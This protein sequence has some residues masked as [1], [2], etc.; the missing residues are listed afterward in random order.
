[1]K[2]FNSATYGILAATA[3][4]WFPSGT[5]AEIDLET[6][7]KKH[8]NDPIACGCRDHEKIDLE[9]RIKQVEAAIKEYESLIKEWEAKERSGKEQL[10][11]TNDNR[12]SVQGSVGFRMST[13]RTPNARSF[14]AET[15]PTCKTWVDPNATPC[16][17][18]A[19]QDHESVHK[20]ACDANK[21][22][23]PFV[24]WRSKQRLVDY[25]REE[26]AGYQ[27]ELDRLKSELETMK[28][29]CSLDKSVRWALENRVAEQ[30]RQRAAYDRVD[31]LRKVL[32]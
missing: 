27:K 18:G 10:L 31:G 2:I 6:E 32:R 17:K 19:L 15:D 7:I 22:M 24:D 4:V 12:G 5:G 14:A 30:E 26:Q 13:V 9:S 25:M 16:L 20:K 1:M 23:N 8:Q 28:K 29:Y 11:L 21:S 3:L